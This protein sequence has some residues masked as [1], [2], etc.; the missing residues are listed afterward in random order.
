MGHNIRPIGYRE[1]RALESG[2]GS[3]QAPGEL[4]SSSP[5]SIIEQLRDLN[6]SEGVNCVCFL[7]RNDHVSLPQ[8]NQPEFQRRDRLKN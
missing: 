7:F 6:I 1:V 5:E 2:E 8:V 3:S 4:L